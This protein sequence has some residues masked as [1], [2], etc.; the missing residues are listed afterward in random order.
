[1]G[2][3]FIPLKSPARCLA[4]GPQA[5][6]SPPQHVAER[7]LLFGRGLLVEVDDDPVGVGFLAE[8]AADDDP[9]ETV[10]GD[11]PDVA[12]VDVDRVGVVASVAL[13]R[14]LVEPAG[15]GRAAAAPDDAGANHLERGGLRLR[16]GGG[17]LGLR[18]ATGGG[19]QGQNGRQTFHTFL[20]L[21]Y[22]PSP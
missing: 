12:A 21:R 9:V 8:A 6:R 22:P 11:G 20:L 10:H 15:A 2:T 13:H 18:R 4:F 17:R 3:R 7:L 14:L 16:G 5:F 1:M 19:D